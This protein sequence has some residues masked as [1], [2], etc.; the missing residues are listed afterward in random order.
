M[1]LL[2]RRTFVLWVE[3]IS[4]AFVFLSLYPKADHVAAVFGYVCSCSIFFLNMANVF[5]NSHGRKVLSAWLICFLYFPAQCCLKLVFSLSLSVSL[6]LCSYVEI[7]PKTIGANSPE[8]LKKECYSK[9]HSN[10][11]YQVKI[12]TSA[13]DI[14]HLNLKRNE[15]S[16][17]E[18]VRKNIFHTVPEVF[19]PCPLIYTLHDDTCPSML[20]PTTRCYC[21]SLLV[22]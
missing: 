8:P 3:P 14:L 9:F 5:R 4:F 16:N 12:S 1:Y 6:S 19:L 11:F 7:F 17:D 18:N 15:V 2:I 10:G 20:E 21:T 22:L 13:L